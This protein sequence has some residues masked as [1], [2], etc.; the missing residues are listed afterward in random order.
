MLRAKECTLTPFVVFTFGFA[1]EFIKELRGA[2]KDF[3]FK[4]QRPVD[5][6]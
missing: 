2:L 5:H 1:V 3:G 6:V 4:V